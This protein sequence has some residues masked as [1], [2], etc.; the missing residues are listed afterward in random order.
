MPYRFRRERRHRHELTPL[1]ALALTV[2]PHP[3]MPDAPPWPSDEHL[4]ALWLEHREQL[5][6]KSR[7]G[8]APWAYWY[9]EDVP[10]P[11]RATRPELVEVGDDPD[12]EAAARDSR[13]EAADELDKRR[14]AWLAE[15]GI[16][17]A[18][19]P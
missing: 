12:V 11:L 8:T 17:A 7:P 16:A 1:T 3:V 4:L 5:I 19:T 13:R 14:G 18:V 2:G 9:F 15:H 10:E 6:A